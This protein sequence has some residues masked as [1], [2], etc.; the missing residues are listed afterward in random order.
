MEKKKSEDCLGTRIAALLV[1][2]QEGRGLEGHSVNSS[3]SQNPRVASALPGV[4]PIESARI[5]RSGCRGRRAW[6]APASAWLAGAG[7]ASIGNPTGPAT[8]RPGDR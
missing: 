3:D 2:Y 4:V 5:R 7:R 8:S 6:C 1:D